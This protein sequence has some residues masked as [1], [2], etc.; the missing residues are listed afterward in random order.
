MLES[1][2]RQQH[3]SKTASP[4]IAIFLFLVTFGDSSTYRAIFSSFRRTSSTLKQLNAL[5]LFLQR[6]IKEKKNPGPAL[7]P[8][9]NSCLIRKVGQGLTCSRRGAN[10]QSIVTKDNAFA[11]WAWKQGV[12]SRLIYWVTFNVTIRQ[13]FLFLFKCRT[14]TI[15]R[16]WRSC[17]KGFF[18][19]FHE[20]NRLE[21]CCHGCILSC[22][23]TLY[24]NWCIIFNGSL[25]IPLKAPPCIFVT[26]N[27]ILNVVL[28][29]FSRREQVAPS[30]H[31]V[32]VPSFKIVGLFQSARIASAMAG[33]RRKRTFW[34]KNQACMS[35][36][37]SSRRSLDCYPGL[38]Y[39][40]SIYLY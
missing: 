11:P 39:I 9:E 1:R 22:G 17:T 14:V 2:C 7:V 31:S 35:I 10:S 38:L 27:F 29:R 6:G 36:G 28:L 34:I 19:T 18:P 40:H 33:S 37:L 4:S 32:G 23:C 26:T 24:W 13:S 16:R 25:R 8:W 3:R 15:G 21:P 5:I 20:L 12:E 30:M